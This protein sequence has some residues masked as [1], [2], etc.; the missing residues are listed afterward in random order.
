MLI[1]KS[2]NLLGF[3]FWRELAR[4]N[5]PS[6]HPGV[7]AAVGRLASTNSISVPGV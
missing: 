4:V 3:S 2:T 5:G 6:A 7:L 1:S